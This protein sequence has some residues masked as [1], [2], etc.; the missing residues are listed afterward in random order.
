VQGLQSQNQPA[1]SFGRFSRHRQAVSPHWVGHLAA[2]RVKSAEGD[3]A[4]AVKQ[5]QA[6]QAAGVPEQQKQNVE[7]ILRR[8]EAGEDINKQ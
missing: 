8:L 3:F 7:K 5:I 4:S 2:A 6:A 1:E